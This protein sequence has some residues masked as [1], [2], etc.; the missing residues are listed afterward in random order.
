MSIRSQNETGFTVLKQIDFRPVP[1][2]WSGTF[3]K[4]LIWRSSPALIFQ[5]VFE[6]FQLLRFVLPY[7]TFGNIRFVLVLSPDWSVRWHFLAF[8]P[9]GLRLILLIRQLSRKIL[10]QIFDFWLFHRFKKQAHVFFR[11]AQ[12]GMWKIMKKEQDIKFK[13]VEVGIGT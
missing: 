12:V 4:L 9:N 2:S 8:E 7:C 6:T 10:E 5:T 1:L 11:R 13:W 3:W